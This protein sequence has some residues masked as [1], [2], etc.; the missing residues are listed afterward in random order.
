MKKVYILLLKIVQRIRCK[1]GRNVCQPYRKK[2]QILTPPPPQKKTT[3]K[4]YRR[5]CTN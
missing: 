1:I 5:K 3:R 2:V 4:M